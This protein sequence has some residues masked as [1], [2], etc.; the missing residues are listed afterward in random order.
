MVLYED[1][2]QQP[3][4]HKNIHAYCEQ[5]GIKI[6]RQALNVGDY[7]IA[8]KG[9]I[10]VDTKYGVAEIAMDVFQD[11]ERFRKECERAKECG[12]QLIVLIEEVLPGGR[13]DNWRSPIGKDGLPRH[14]FDPAILRK[15]MITMQEKYGVRFR[16]CDG[17]STGKVLIEYL[18][19]ERT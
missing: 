2:R 13:L 3:G 11:H 19:G 16:F 8:N 5:A 4:K 7:Q 9:D 10:V 15:A 1:S 12:I 6:I 18:K 17:R 14:K